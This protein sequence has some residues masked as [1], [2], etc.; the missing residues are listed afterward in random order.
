[1]STTFNFISTMTKSA[2]RPQTQQSE[3]INTNSALLH[4]SESRCETST[5]RSTQTS[6][7]PACHLCCSVHKLRSIA[8]HGRGGLTR[9]NWHV[10]IAA[11]LHTLRITL[12][13]YVNMSLCLCRPCRSDVDLCGL[14][15]CI[16]T[17]I[18][19]TSRSCFPVSSSRFF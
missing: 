19:A 1:M 18:L 12:C 6:A 14:Q 16:L 8:H 17:L 3:T 15:P 11:A 13:H 10:D 9:V 2:S 7:N 5:K 4:L